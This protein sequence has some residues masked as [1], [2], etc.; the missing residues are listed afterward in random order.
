M[1]VKK[2]AEKELKDG[3]ELIFEGDNCV[4]IQGVSFWNKWHKGRSICILKIIYE[5]VL[6]DQNNVIKDDNGNPVK[7]PT[8]YMVF[9]LKNEDG[10]LKNER[11]AF[12]E[13]VWKFVRNSI[14][15]PVLTKEEKEAILDDL[16]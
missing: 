4:N 15:R 16:L 9:R 2:G 12:M 8:K 5:E 10:T 11:G 3:M 1:N 7:I 14:P 6:D 13:K